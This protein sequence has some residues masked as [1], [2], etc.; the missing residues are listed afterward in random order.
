[1]PDIQIFDA[2][3]FMAAKIA[4][5]EQ[6]LISKKAELEILYAN[7]RNL[8]QTIASL[9]LL[10]PEHQRAIQVETASLKEVLNSTERSI[11]ALEGEAEMLT[12]KLAALQAARNIISLRESP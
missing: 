9:G 11:A 12:G 7:R 1:M 5:T 6:V 10:Q 4:E 2:N 8:E 3:G